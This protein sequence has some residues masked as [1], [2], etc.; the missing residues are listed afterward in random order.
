MDFYKHR[1]SSEEAYYKKEFTYNVIASFWAGALASGLTNG[2]EV[3]AVN[4]Q[5]NPHI[6]LLS[7]IKREKANLFTKGLGARVYYMSLQSVFFFTCVLYIGKL[8]NV[9][10]TEVA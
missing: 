6:N 5:A 9:D 4:K 2:F 8:Y 10:L 3:L 7:L 1:A